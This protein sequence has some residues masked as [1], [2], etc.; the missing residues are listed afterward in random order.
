VLDPVTYDEETLKYPVSSTIEDIVNSAKIDELDLID[1]L[2]CPFMVLVESSIV[3][4]Y[5]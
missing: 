5:D 3:R 2:K 4:K 1:I